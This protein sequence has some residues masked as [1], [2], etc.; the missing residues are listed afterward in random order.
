MTDERDLR[1]DHE[2]D[3]RVGAWLTDT[4]LSPDEASIGFD[5]LLDEFPVTP[6]ARRR[7]LGRWLDRDEG[8]GR[9]TS[10]HDHPPNI[11]RR[12]R[13]MLSATGVTA[14]LAIFAIAV[15]VTDTDQL[16]PGAEGGATHVVAADGSAD[17]TTIQA[18]VEAAAAGDTIAIQPGTYAESVTIDK[19]LTVAGDGPREAIVVEIGDDGPSLDEDRQIS[20]G[21]LLLGADTSLGNLTIKGSG[22]RTVAVVA[23]G[24]SPVLHELSV[25]LGPLAAYPRAFAYLV[26]GTDAVVRDNEANA[27]VDVDGAVA[28]LTGNVTTGPDKANGF[29]VWAGNDSD[30]EIS[31]NLLNGVTIDSATARVVQNELFAP[32]GC[33]LEILGADTMMT[34]SENLIRASEAGICTSGGAAGSFETNKIVD[35]GTGISLGSDVSVSG[36]QLHDNDVAVLFRVGSPTVEGNDISG[37]RAALA[38]G[39]LPVTPSISGNSLCTNEVNV[40]APDGVEP[41]SLDDDEI[42]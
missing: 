8:A 35:N 5:R 26:N 11:N 7:F 14:A 28:T 39:S 25:E 32:D 13:I 17:F 2:M 20:Y 24:G 29:Q 18:A 30:V 21:F 3:G 16:T 42:C 31:G 37:N 38:F 41:P 1:P 19:D 40:E 33:A 6:Q 23:D 9:R 10:E 22:L 27:E 4:D 34:A 12:N 15:N 36:N